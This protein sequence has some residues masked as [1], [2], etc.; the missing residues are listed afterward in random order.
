[1][2]DVLEDLNIGTKDHITVTKALRKV[3]QEEADLIRKTEEAISG[4]ASLKGPRGSRA[5]RGLSQ[6][7]DGTFIG[8]PG[9]STATGFGSFKAP[10][11]KKVAKSVQELTDEL[12]E[13]TKAS[14]GSINSLTKQRNRLEEL[15]G[16]LD[17]TS[18]TFARLTNE[19]RKTD[20]AL[21][22]LSGNKFSG[23]NLRRTGQSILGA[24]FVGGPAGFL[25]AGLGAGFEALRPGGDM[26]G[27]AITG[28]LIA[29]QVARPVTEFIGG[30]T[31]YA[32][33]YKK[34][35]KTLKLI[36]KDAGSYG[37]AM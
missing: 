9:P 7:A 19:I 21:M 3:R 37:V 36:T 29:S 27:G 15:R 12:L 35:E 30:S 23:A 14:K 6:T 10:E 13:N 11:V 25:G 17:P 4:K 32:A 28:G 24:G 31:E 26:A 33:D 18:K 5:A 34:S 1:M 2:E 22:K 16:N 20:A 8:L